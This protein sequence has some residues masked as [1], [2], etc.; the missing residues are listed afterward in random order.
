MTR[1]VLSRTIIPT[2]MP[3]IRTTQKHSN[4]DLDGGSIHYDTNPN[5]GYSGGSIMLM[6]PE[7]HFDQG[8]DTNPVSIGPI[9]YDTN[10]IDTQEMISG[11][12]VGIVKCTRIPFSFSSLDLFRVV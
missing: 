7:P 1:S 12:P 6:L 9:H 4:T 3:L 5:G 10:P 2:P 8:G 11:D